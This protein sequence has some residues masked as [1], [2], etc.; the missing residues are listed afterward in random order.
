MRILDLF[1]GAG[2]A[3]MGYVLAGHTV[4]GVDTEPQPDYPFEFHQA[5]ALGFDL[6]GYDAI[7]ASPP[8]QHGA[9]IT[10]GTN[11]HLRHTYRD[12]YPATK[13]LL[14]YSGRPYV[15]ENP[16]ARPDLILCGEMFGLNVIR[17]RRFEFGN[18]P[19][20]ITLAHKRHRGR[21]RGWRHGKYVDGPYLAAYGTGGG[22]A[23][24][25]EIRDAMQVYWITERRGL[26]DAIP[27]AYTRFIGEWL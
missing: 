17:H 24:D 20:I 14:E 1:C 25:Q 16:D 7:H 11:A 15:I 13:E 27:P 21:V 10:R 3:S 19:G 6:S 9:A 2:G 5:D 8:C 18:V 4:V 22:K 26:L 12:L 23:T